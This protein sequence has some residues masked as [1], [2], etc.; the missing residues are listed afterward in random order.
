V[1][2]HVIHDQETGRIYAGG[3]NPWTGVGVWQSD[4]L[5]ESWREPGDGLAYEGDDPA[6]KSIWSLALSGDRL[7]AGVEPAGLFVSSD[8]GANFTHVHGLR[9]HPTRA[10]WQPGG[11]G[12]ILHTIVPD[13]ED[14][15]QMWVGISVAGVYRTGDGG[16]TWEPRN[17]GTR[18][19]YNPEDQRYPEHGQCV[20]AI[21][22]AP[23][24]GER[25]YQ[26]N[27]CGMYRSDDG[28]KAWESIEDGLPSSFGFPVVVHPRDPDTVFL[29]P[30]NGDSAGRYVPEA[31]AAVWRS[32][33]AGRSWQDLRNGL[34]QKDAYLCILRQAFAADT[35]DE[36]GLYFGSNSGSLFASADEGESWRQIAQHLPIIFSVETAV[37][38]T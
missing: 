6:I 33:D 32:K 13:S 24:K 4:D 11:G 20:H 31:K 29:I 22:R 10:D 12:L 34:P 1:I 35:L 16:R 27:H 21:T 30:L 18:A 5:G 2:H 19:D 26:Q 9:D 23:G 3:G 36:V 17:R 8:G 38:E 15:D 25:L 37:V 28:G 14:A 7:Y